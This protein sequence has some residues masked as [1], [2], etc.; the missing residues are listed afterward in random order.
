MEL[1]PDLVRDLVGD[2]EMRIVKLVEER[3]LAES[4]G[5]KQDSDRLE[6]EIAALH[7]ELARVADIVAREAVSG[8]G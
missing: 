4:D 3:E 8:D 1:D 5:R 6:G 7:L 2:L